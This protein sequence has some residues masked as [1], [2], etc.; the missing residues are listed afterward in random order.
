MVLIGVLGVQL[1]VRAG[2][3]EVLFAGR[4]ETVSINFDVI[5]DELHDCRE[6]R[7][8]RGGVASG[9]SDD[10]EE[11]VGFGAGDA[12]EVFEFRYTGG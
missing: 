11:D 1:D 6:G 12:V 8:I 4:H 3:A 2:G 7:G 5:L 9:G 10:A